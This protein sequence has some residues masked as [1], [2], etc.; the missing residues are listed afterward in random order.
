MSSAQTSKTIT[1]LERETSLDFVRSYVVK[2]FLAIAR[3]DISLF[4]LI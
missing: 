2:R 3:N 4:I 1:C